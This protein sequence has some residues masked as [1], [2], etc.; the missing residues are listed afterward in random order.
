MT[1]YL[2][3][4]LP[5]WL[6]FAEFPL[7]VSARR[8]R[9][10][11]TV[12]TAVCNWALDSGGFSEIAMFGRWETPPEQYADEVQEWSERIGRMQWAAIQD[13][14]CEP[15]M[16]EKTGLSIDEH[17]RRTVRSWRTL[18]RIAPRLP[19]VPVL[20]GWAIG[21]YWK[22]AAMYEAEGV[23]LQALPTVGVGSVCRR[24]A[25]E[26]AESL[27]RQ[28]SEE[29]IRAH[30]FGFKTKGLRACSSYMASADSLA[31]SYAA[32]R[33]EPLEGCEHKSCANCF[34]YA[35]RWRTGVMDSIA[36]GQQRPVYRSLFAG[37]A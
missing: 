27:M 36:R 17:Q 21:D 22:H 24:Q 14:M 7:F 2:G 28:L 19:W 11:R 26:E 8:L 1:F 5:N 3:T 6:A 31:W 34:R 9:G 18:N 29:G 35:C 25:T 16:I 32:R 37:M 33:S 20:Q 12:P 23:D 30:G 10:R 4:H 13:W 15:F